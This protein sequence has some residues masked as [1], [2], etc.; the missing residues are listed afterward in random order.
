MLYQVDEMQATF[1]VESYHR[2]YPGIR[3][4]HRIIVKELNQ[5]RTLYNL[6]GR[7]RVFLDRWNRDLWKEAYSY[8]PQST[9]AELMNQN[10][11]RF[12]YERQDLFPEVHL[13]NTVHDSLIYQVPLSVGTDRMTEII[14]LVKKNLELPL[15]A[16]GRSFSIPVDTKIGFTLDEAK[17][18]ELKAKD[19]KDPAQVSQRIGDF[20]RAS[21]T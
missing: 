18:L 13:L 16:R 7:K 3:R 17:M 12:V 21:S 11:V 4:W 10:G 19:T 15:T 14:S 8:I 5:T 1:L 9:V 6:F 20:L 2:I